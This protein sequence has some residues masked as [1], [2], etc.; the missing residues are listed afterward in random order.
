VHDAG[1]DIAEQ[2]LGF[3]DELLAV[4]LIQEQ[5]G[6]GGGAQW[7]LRRVKRP[8]RILELGVG[9]RQLFLRF[10]RR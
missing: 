3:P 4:T 9:S 5:G 6:V 10:L 8:A 2:L 7:F 1:H